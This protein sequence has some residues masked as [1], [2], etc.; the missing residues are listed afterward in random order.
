MLDSATKPKKSGPSQREAPSSLATM[1]VHELLGIGHA[2]LRIP[3][4]FQLF[5]KDQPSAFRKRF[6]K[7]FRDS[8]Q[9]TKFRAGAETA[10][11]AKKFN[12]ASEEVQQ[13]YHADA[14]ALKDAAT[15]RR[16]AL[17]GKLGGR[18]DPAEAQQFVFLPAILASCTNAARHRL[19]HDFPF[20]MDPL[21]QYLSTMLNAKIS[22]L[23]AVPEPGQGGKLVIK[24]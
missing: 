19:I 5:A 20:L 21:M 6:L 22:L 10:W 18:L 16:E 7:S 3:H 13:K 14:Q 17:S 4:A 2:A 12:A 15:T 11:N 24:A 8:G 23:M 9:S 1:L